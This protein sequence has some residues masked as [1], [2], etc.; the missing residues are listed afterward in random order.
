MHSYLN[1]GYVVITFF[2][3]P[4]WFLYE[5]TY[6]NV[7]VFVG[8]ENLDELVSNV[9]QRVNL[10]NGERPIILYED[11]EGDKIVLATDN[12]LVTAVN[13]TRSAGV[14]SLKLY[15]E[16]GNST[17]PTPTPLQSATANRQKT[18]VVSLRSGIFASAIVITSIGILVYLKRSK[19]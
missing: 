4:L 2:P 6:V 18:S 15:L 7:T 16:F 11:D 5:L 3:T 12:D 10:E 9:M 14:K 8:T 17:K 1:L 19:Q 13:Y